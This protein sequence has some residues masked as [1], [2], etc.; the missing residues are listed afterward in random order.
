MKTNPENPQQSD[1]TKSELAVYDYECLGYTKKQAKLL[2][3]ETSLDKID[4]R[5]IRLLLKKA[6]EIHDD[7]R[8]PY[9]NYLKEKFTKGITRNKGG[10]NRSPSGRRHS[11]NKKSK[12]EIIGYSRKQAMILDGEI[13]ADE[14]DGRTSKALLKKAIKL[15]DEERIPYIMQLIEVTDKVRECNRREFGCDNYAKGRHFL[16]DLT[17][18][19]CKG[20]TK[21]QSLILDGKLGLDKLDG[22]TTRALLRK[23]EK[24]HDDE[25]IPFIQ[26]LIETTD[27]V[28]ACNIRECHNDNNRFCYSKS[29]L[30]LSG[31]TKRQA[32]ILCGEIGV[33]EID[34]RTSRAL[35]KRALDLCDEEHIPFIL[36]LVS[37]ADAQKEQYKRGVSSIKSEFEK[38]GYTKRQAQIL[39]G[40]LGIY[41]IDGHTSKALLKRAIALGDVEHIPF[42]K[43]LV[44]QTDKIKKIRKATRDKIRKHN[45]K[46]NV[47]TTWKEPASSEYTKEQIAVIRGEVPLEHVHSTRLISI[48]KKARKRGDYAL[49]DTINAV[50]MDRRNHA[51]ISY[52]Q[53]KEKFINN[54][55]TDIF[56]DNST[57]L[58]PWEYDL[59]EQKIELKKSS[60]EH[61][62]HIIKVCHH[63]E[64]YDLE[65]VA[66][67]LLR[68]KKDP[69]I[70]LIT[71]DREEAIRLY[72]QMTGVKVKRPEEWTL[73]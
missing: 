62:E 34:G 53:V 2:A 9:I 52:E 58:A 40:E 26:G 36:E 56:D 15:R 4:G 54:G 66:E 23:A 17:E 8:I 42:I 46:N 19:E 13:G 33:D 20:Y 24:L 69:S 32:Q 5:S 25:H 39:N 57:T 41:D 61:L 29:E 63:N 1:I 45:F 64:D 70:I 30:E 22:R 31:Y 37:I 51:Y 14:I 38:K 48:C 71:T 68:I 7:E 49:A 60:V 12:I 43:N 16:K 67:Y 55:W 6:I 50:I 72:E 35:L 21:K 10:N 59:L 44:K 28:K 73:N 27:K 65:K 3:G 18:H 11:Y 47:P